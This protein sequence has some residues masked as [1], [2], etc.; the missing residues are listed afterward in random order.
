MPNRGC[1]AYD[2][3]S[4]DKTKKARIKASIVV[5]TQDEVIPWR[6]D[7]WAKVLESRPRRGIEGLV[8]K[9]DHRWVLSGRPL[10][11]LG[12]TFA[13]RATALFQ[14]VPNH[15]MGETT[16]LSTGN[17]SR[18]P[19]Q[20]YIGRRKCNGFDRKRMCPISRKRQ[21]VLKPTCFKLWVCTNLRTA[22]KRSTKR[23]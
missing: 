23:Q 16:L 4:V 12:S 5:F 22:L 21:N 8:D 10:R 2:A 18:L 6:H 9:L 17:A 13:N 15:S 11:S 14:S 20:G 1:P 7:H 3:N 19:E